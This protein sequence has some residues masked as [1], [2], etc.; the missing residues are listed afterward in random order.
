[1]F[2]KSNLIHA[3]IVGLLFLLPT[4]CA[5]DAQAQTQAYFLNT[6]PFEVPGKTL[7]PEYLIEKKTVIEAYFHASINKGNYSG[8]FVVAKNGQ[9][10]YEEHQGYSNYEEK[11]ESDK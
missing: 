3:S 5:K 1:M 2:K 11:K 9:I 7:T 8:G 6:K 4:S 10:I